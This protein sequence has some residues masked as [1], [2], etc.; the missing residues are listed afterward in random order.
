MECSK[1]YYKNINLIRLIA[2]LGVLLYHFGILKGGYL[3]VCIFFVLS[4]YLSCISA[5]RKEKFSLLKYYS[6]RL[7]KIYVPLLAV[8]F[9]TIF[10][11][12]L[13]P[14]I[15]W[16]NLKPETTSVL[17]GYN[18]FWQ[19]S[20]NLD[21]F[22]RHVNSP[23]IHL[24]Y[25]S[26][27]LQFDLVFP[28]IYIPLRKLGDKINKI[29]P[30]IITTILAIIGSIYFYKMNLTKTMMVT[31]YNT[32]TRIFSLLFGLSL[33]FIKSY[34]G[35]LIPKIFKKESINKIIFYAYLLMLICLFIFIDVN[36]EYYAFSMILVS[37]ITLRLID[38]GTIGVDNNLSF[39]D[40][41]VKSLSDVSYEIY[42]FQY[43]I[44]FL[45]QYININSYLKIPLMIILILVL[46]YILH[47]CINNKAKY[48][49][50]KYII[51]V[52]VIGISLGGLYKYV[53]AEDHTKEMKALEEQLKQNE[54]IINQ[55]KEE[56][57]LKLKQEQESWMATLNDLENG[58]ANLKDTVKNLSV[59]GI[60]DSVMLGAVD[61]L[62]EQFPN[63][64]IDAQISRTAWVANGIL[65]NLKNRNM[66]G[67]IVVLNL[68]A[69]G[70]CD[71]YCKTEIMNTCEGRKVF[72]VNTTNYTY[73]NNAL[74]SFAS[75]YNNLYVIDWYS[76]SKEHYE[77][78]IA[79]GIHL[80]DIGKN[81][82]TNAIYESIYNVY[83]DE[84]N[85]KK[86]EIINEYEEKQKTKISFYGNDI[87]LNAFDYIQTNFEE[88]KFNIKNEL[89]FE[90]LKQEIETA[91][92]DEALTYKIVF[93]FDDSLSLSSS[94]YQQLIE[95]CEG[96]EIY[97]LL[98]NENKELLNTNYEKVTFINFFNE[99]Q[100]NPEYLMADKIHLTI[101]GNQALSDILSETIK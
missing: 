22:A 52:I 14:N 79:D 28:F 66:L 76:I 31:Y 93:A 98:T 77:Y 35:Q 48:K 3:A 32:F 67:N 68:G 6:N 55:K 94:E 43:P 61:A 84:Y 69:N 26:I 44:I 83:L 85:Q 21:Y 80:T 92:K 81:A 20:A 100:N 38:Y 45:F 97:I 42:L 95:L 49:I 58:E 19:L 53:L 7:L 9:I 82:Y 71:E 41:I 75:K 50:T 59:V 39:F 33:G 15:N 12:S 70:D 78:F 54:E 99:I 5:F 74:N 40:K 73:V 13:F 90:T 30:C 25:I 46:S 65:Q 11:I 1:K 57:A 63:S 62:Y 72:W 34:Y 86:H 27:L 36:S 8:V 89:S 37:I 10:V 29:I 24:W 23:F 64:Y 51:S 60:G 18:N 16:L 2:C 4:G 87:L 88:A 56:Y 91:K 47:F 96:H 17:L 101:D